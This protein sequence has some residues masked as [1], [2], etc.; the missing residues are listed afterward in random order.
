MFFSPVSS[1]FCPKQF[2]ESRHV[3]RRQNKSRHIGE[4]RAGPLDNVVQVSFA[5][6]LHLDWRPPEYKSLTWSTAQEFLGSPQY[7]VHTGV[8]D[9]SESCLISHISFI[10]CGGGIIHADDALGLIDRRAEA[11]IKQV[12]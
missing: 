10:A 2:I 6:L 12:A 7:A 4:S 1:C 8:C 5:V 11:G 3:P 9:H